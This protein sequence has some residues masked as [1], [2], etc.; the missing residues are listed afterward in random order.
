MAQS[1]L[2]GSQIVVKKVVHPSVHLSGYFFFFGIRS[3]AFLIFGMVIQIN[4]KLCITEA[5]IFREKKFSKM[6][7][8]GQ[9]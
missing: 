9:K 7:K 3:S 8:M 4:M 5:N 2:W 1:L 6:V